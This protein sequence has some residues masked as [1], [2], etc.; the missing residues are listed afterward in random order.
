MNPQLYF[1]VDTRL[2]G[3]RKAQFGPYGLNWEHVELVVY[4]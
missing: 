3:K 2:Y 4:G 1:C